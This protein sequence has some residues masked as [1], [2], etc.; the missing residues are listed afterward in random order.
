M[1]LDIF[2]F[3]RFRFLDVKSRRKFIRATHLISNSRENLGYLAR[4]NVERR[5]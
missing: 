5:C 4:I 1:K 2:F 3:I